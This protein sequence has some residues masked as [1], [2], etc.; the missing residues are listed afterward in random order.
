MIVLN[1]IYVTFVKK[2]QFNHIDVL[3]M[4]AIKTGIDDVKI[5]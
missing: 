2:Y 5:N 3:E 1:K 4:D